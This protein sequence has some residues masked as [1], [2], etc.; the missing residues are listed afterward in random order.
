MERKMLPKNSN[1][2]LEGARPLSRQERIA[3][4]EEQLG[5][6]ES[7]LSRQVAAADKLYKNLGEES[8]CDFRVGRFVDADSTVWQIY[9]NYANKENPYG[10]L[11]ICCGPDAENDSGDPEAAVQEITENSCAEGRYMPYVMPKGVKAIDTLHF[12]GRR[13]INVF[14]KGGE[15]LVVADSLGRELLPLDELIAKKNAKKNDT[16]N[17]RPEEITADNKEDD[18]DKRFKEIVE[19]SLADVEEGL[20]AAAVSGTVRVA[21]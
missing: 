18:T 3:Q 19:S 10:W 12:A 14:W 2:K 15:E 1:P 11:V 8:G 21:A 16:D 4:L 6:K 9:N 13:S 5:Q 7:R 17:K 20:G